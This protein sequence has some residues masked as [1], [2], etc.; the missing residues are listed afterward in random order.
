MLGGAGDVQVFNYVVE[1]IP[2][3]SGEVTEVPVEGGA[4]IE[5]GDVLFQIDRRPFQ[6]EVDRLEAALKEEK[7][8]AL[9]LETDLAAATG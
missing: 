7:Q 2:N 1:I 4:P 3:V 8:A 6:A 5:K 9:I